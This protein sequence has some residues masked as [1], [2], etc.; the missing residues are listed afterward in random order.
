MNNFNLATK[1]TFLRILAAPILVLLLYFPNRY[2]CLA[3]L[4]VFIF[5]AV[6]DMLDGIIARRS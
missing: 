2:T 6:T 1:I 5:A 4:V 3:A